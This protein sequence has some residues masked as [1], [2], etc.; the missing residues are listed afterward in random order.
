M[1]AS[2]KVRSAFDE[3]KLTEDRWVEVHTKKLDVMQRVKQLE[4]HAT[5]VTDEI[6]RS[7]DL[8]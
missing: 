2:E 1:F 4:A 8:V 5:K 6:N 7:Q 3:F